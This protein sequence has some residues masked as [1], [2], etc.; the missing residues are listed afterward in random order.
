MDVSNEIRITFSQEKAKALFIVL[1][2]EY[3]SGAVYY[4]GL[5]TDEAEML[6]DLRNELYKMLGVDGASALC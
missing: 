5:T 4:N 1:D 3:I 2:D 6:G